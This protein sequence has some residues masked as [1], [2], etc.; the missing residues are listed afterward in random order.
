[1]AGLA[2]NKT[3]THQKRREQWLIR[4][5][6]HLGD[7]IMAEPA[8]AAL[9]R[10]YDCKIVGPRFC[11]EIYAHLPT[12]D[13]SPESVVL[14][15]PSNAEGFRALRYKRRVGLDRRWLMTDSICSRLDH[16]IDNNNRIAEHLGAKPS[17]DPIFPGQGKT[18]KL[19]ARFA[20]FIVGTASP[21][22]VLWTQYP[23]L[24]AAVEINVLFAGGPGDENNVT[25]LGAKHSTLPT[26]LT[27]GE[28]ASVCRAAEWIIG[29]DCGLMHLACAARPNNTQHF[30]VI[31]STDPTRTAPRNSHVI[32]DD[33]PSCWPCYKKRC[34]H[35]RSCLTT[36]YKDV[37]S[38]INSCL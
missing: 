36:P 35:D 17:R 1:M 28:F 4:A 32:M 2:L 27:L 20:L 8:I 24:A 5:P 22:T 14:F 15:K 26:D 31:G 13:C 33:R 37:L 21:E 34:A 11:Q 19:P 7:A 30:V 10:Q 16:R 29:S 38:R 25:A 23:A 18:P 6:D 12:V 3:K 9:C